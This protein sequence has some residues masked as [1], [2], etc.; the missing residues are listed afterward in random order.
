MVDLT[1]TDPKLL[2]RYM[3]ADGFTSF[4]SYHRQ[5]SSDLTPAAHIP[6]NA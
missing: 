4:M 3:E 2:K 6:A 5:L 1:G